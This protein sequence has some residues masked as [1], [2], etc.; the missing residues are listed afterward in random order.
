[1]IASVAASRLSL[2]TKTSTCADVVDLI[3][4]FFE[5]AAPQSADLCGAGKPA[6]TTRDTT[7]RIAMTAV[8]AVL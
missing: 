2:Y 7:T 6:A 1:M 5:S 3:F 8:D 4:A